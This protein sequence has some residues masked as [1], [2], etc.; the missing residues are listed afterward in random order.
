M[1]LRVDV[2]EADVAQVRQGEDA[3]FTVD[4]YPGRT[5]Q[6]QVKR[7]RQA[8]PIEVGATD[9]KRTQVASGDVTPGLE[10]VVDAAGKE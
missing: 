2:D 3:T 7:V 9:G 4:A 1:E 6:A 5:F 10:L 8:S